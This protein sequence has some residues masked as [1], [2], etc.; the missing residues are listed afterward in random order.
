MERGT[1]IQSVYEEG[2]LMSVAIGQDIKEGRV[3][4]V[5]EPVTQ[6][7][8]DYF[9][10]GGPKPGTESVADDAAKDLEA[11]GMRDEE[12]NFIPQAADPYPN[13]H[14]I[15]EYYKEEAGTR[16]TGGQ[17][18]RGGWEQIAIDEDKQQAEEEAAQAAG[19][20]DKTIEDL[21]NPET[22]NSQSMEQPAPGNQQ[23]APPPTQDS[24]QQPSGDL[25]RYPQDAKRA[26]N[27]QGLLY[28][29][30]LRNKRQRL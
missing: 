30:S 26:F 5:Y 24:S 19:A 27:Q 17:A 6:Q 22:A 18:V 13:P 4:E 14:Y 2:E 25:W 15:P 29:D 28:D 20:G 10:R 23:N 9:F 1:K 3:P 7:D 21:P 12:G 8:L 11:A 16:P